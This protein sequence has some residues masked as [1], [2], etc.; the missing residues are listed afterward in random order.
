MAKYPKSILN[1]TSDEAREFFLMKESYCSLNLPKY[2]DF[3]NLLK[4]AVSVLG[5][6]ELDTKNNQIFNEVKNEKGVLKAVKYSDFQDINYTFQLN[7]TKTTYRPVTIIHPYLY[8]DLVNCITNKENWGELINRLNG[9]REKSK[10]KIVCHSIPFVPEEKGD[11]KKEASLNFWKSIEQE[12]IKLSLEYN[13]ITQVDIS[14]FYGSI[15]THTIPWAIHGIT[16]AKKDKKDDNLLGNKIDK[17]FQ[18]MNNCETVTIPQGNKISDFIAEILLAYLDHQLLESL[19]QQEFSKPF[20]ILRYRDDYRIFTNS[21]E[22]ASYI[23]RELISIL[24]RHK[25]S[26]GESKTSQS[27]DVIYASIKEDKH[28]WI[29]NDPVIKITNDKIY[30]KPKQFALKFVPFLRYGSKKLKNDRFKWIMDNRIYTATVQKHLL[31]IKKFADQYPNS[32]QLIGA[33]KEFDNRIVDWKLKDFEH[34]GTD[35]AV[36]LSI[37]TDIVKNNPKVTDSGVKTISYLLNCIDYKISFYDIISSLRDHREIKSD[38]EYKLLLLTQIY[39]NLAKFSYNDY[40]EIWFQRLVVK[41]LGE[42]SPFIDD[43]SSKVSNKFVKLVCEVMRNKQP[44]NR[45]SIFC[46]DWIKDD[47][48]IDIISFINKD[49]IDILDEV[50]SGF[51]INTSEY[52]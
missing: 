24:Q 7:K 48:K 31:I 30:Q 23:K 18:Y 4:Q 37:V 41:N 42:D 45:V 17:K 9:L 12:S 8:V 21:I 39:S 19:D 13:Y 28:Y 34:A 1:L 35:I 14:N 33:F 49:E 16:K 50:I 52:I 43:Y 20:K 10:D 29:N 47:K 38:Y 44:K 22:D 25:L 6:S 26:L 5:V 2:F 15:Y 36:L 32:G 11:E 46:E 27:S 51:E 40:L 3:E